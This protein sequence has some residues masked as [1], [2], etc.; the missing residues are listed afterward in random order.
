MYFTCSHLLEPFT[1]N[2][3]V[4]NQQ[5]TTVDG[6]IFIC[7]IGY[8]IM[9]RCVSANLRYQLTIPSPNIKTTTTTTTT[10]TK[11]IIIIEGVGEGEKKSG[12]DSGSIGNNIITMDSNAMETNK[13]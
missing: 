1:G 13:V 7:Y 2:E 3:N 4:V 11:I 10:T 12:V 8:Y 9:K 5:Y 6:N